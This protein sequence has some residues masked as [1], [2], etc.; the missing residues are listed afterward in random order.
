MST[1]TLYNIQKELTL[2]EG[3]ASNNAETRWLVQLDHTMWFVHNASAVHKYDN[4]VSIP[5]YPF[6]LMTVLSTCYGY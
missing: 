6:I 4:I 5:V 3:K 2:L 1:Q